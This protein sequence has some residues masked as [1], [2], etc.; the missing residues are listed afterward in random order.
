MWLAPS[1]RKEIRGQ[2]SEVRRS[3]VRKK[4]FYLWERLSAAIL[5]ISTNLTNSNYL[6]LLDSLI[7]DEVARILE[8]D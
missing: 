8:S 6:P 4:G 1:F 3:E 7:N 5:T 2:K